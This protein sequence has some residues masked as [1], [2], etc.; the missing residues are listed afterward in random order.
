MTS[1]NR[2]SYAFGRPADKDFAG[3]TEQG[4][5]WENQILSRQLP[6]C[7]FLKLISLRTWRLLSFLTSFPLMPSPALRECCCA[8]RQ[9]PPGTRGRSQRL[10]L[11][12][13]MTSEIK[14]LSQSEGFSS[15]FSTKVNEFRSSRNQVVQGIRL[16]LQVAGPQ[17]T[18]CSCL[19]AK[20]RP[21][22]LGFRETLKKWVT[23]Q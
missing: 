18:M 21:S 6:N 17:I 7:S 19:A 8:G 14:P 22:L 9:T 23:W 11:R 13:R 20:S 15:L 2:V 10:V 12:K 4:I 5:V 16:S 3:G 1:Q